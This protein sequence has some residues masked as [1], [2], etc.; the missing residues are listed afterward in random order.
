MPEFPPGPSQQGAQPRGTDRLVVYQACLH[1]PG[2]P[3]GIR[4]YEQMG[5]PEWDF[6]PSRGYAYIRQ[7]RHL[8]ALLVAVGKD[9]P[10]QAY[11]VQYRSFLDR[12]TWLRLLAEPE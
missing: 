8:A 6:S 11:L 5:W 10:T 4:H 1:E 2:W 9:E 12:G 3:R 7:P